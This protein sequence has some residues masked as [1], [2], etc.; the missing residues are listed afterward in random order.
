MIINW[1]CFVVIFTI[2]ALKRELFLGGP[3]S[4]VSVA[5]I[6]VASMF[7]LGAIRG[8]VGRLFN[9]AAPTITSLVL[10]GTVKNYGLAGALALG[11]FEQRTAVPAAVSSAFVVVYLICLG[12][13]KTMGT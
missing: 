13:Q 12:F 10:L 7:V 1:G 2:V 6:A 8:R 3:L 9:M 4:L 11:L 5:C